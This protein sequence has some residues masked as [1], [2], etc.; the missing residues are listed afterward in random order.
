MIYTKNGTEALEKRAVV[1]SP[2]D[3]HRALGHRFLRAEVFDQCRSWTAGDD[4]RHERE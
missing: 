3:G 4:V 2:G 1:I